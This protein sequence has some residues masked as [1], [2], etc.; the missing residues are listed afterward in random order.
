MVLHFL[1]EVD[2]AS[3]ERL[4]EI[5]KKKTEDEKEINEAI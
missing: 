2:P 5:L 1:Q 4:I 3:K